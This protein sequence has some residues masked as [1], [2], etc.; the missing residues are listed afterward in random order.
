MDDPASH[1]HPAHQTSG[2]SEEA[3]RRAR[4]ALTAKT[5]LIEAEHAAGQL[6]AAQAAG[7]LRSARA[8]YDSALAEI[9]PGTGGQ[10]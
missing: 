1:Q 4:A 2:A 8:A 10:R 3:R 9:A 6:T 5:A 7:Q